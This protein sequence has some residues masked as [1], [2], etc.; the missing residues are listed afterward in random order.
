MTWWT[1]VRHGVRVKAY[2]I[3]EVLNKSEHTSGSL[4]VQCLEY[5]RKLGLTLLW[6]E[7]SSCIHKGKPLWCNTCPWSNTQDGSRFTTPRWCQ[8]LRRG[9][10]C[11]LQQ[12]LGGLGTQSGMRLGALEGAQEGC[13]ERAGVSWPW[14]ETSGHASSCGS[15]TGCPRAP[16]IYPVFSRWVTIPLLLAFSA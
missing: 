10:N 7:P 9:L 8:V 6:M 12:A 1:T 16:E 14:W 3:H 11:G 13:L 4:A 2:C 5:P 15:Q